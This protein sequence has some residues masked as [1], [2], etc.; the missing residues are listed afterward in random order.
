MEGNYTKQF[1]NYKRRDFNIIEL[2]F[3]MK[4]D[5]HILEHPVIIA[6]EKVS[7]QTKIK[8]NNSAKIIPYLPKWSGESKKRDLTNMTYLDG[9][10]KRDLSF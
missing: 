3:V 2:V 4:L 10:K 8:L 5:W 9:S 6:S 1:W 7:K